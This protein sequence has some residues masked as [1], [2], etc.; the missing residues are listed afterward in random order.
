MI[1]PVIAMQSMVVVQTVLTINWVRRKIY[2]SSQKGVM[3]TASS[4]KSP[5]RSKIAGGTRA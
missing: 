5:I 3:L 4:P 1:P 2:L